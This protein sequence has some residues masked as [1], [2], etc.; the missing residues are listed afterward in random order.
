MFNLFCFDPYIVSHG[1]FQKLGPVP[2]EGANS[3]LVFKIRSGLFGSE[4]LEFGVSFF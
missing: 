3:E 1:T 2:G 4:F